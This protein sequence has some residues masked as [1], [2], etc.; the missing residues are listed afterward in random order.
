MTKEPN[1]Y[2][3]HQRLEEAT[4]EGVYT[5][6]ERGKLVAEFQA[7]QSR[8]Q[9][10]EEVI[11]IMAEALSHYGI[12]YYTDCFGNKQSTGK[13]AQEALAKATNFRKG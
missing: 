1:L 13:L 4:V 12:T 10:A 9:E 8:L 11:D 6:L 3:E 7:I 5:P 2:P